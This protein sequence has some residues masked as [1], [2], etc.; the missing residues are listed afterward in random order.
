MIRRIR[1]CVLFLVATGVLISQN[2][3]PAGQAKPP[4]APAPAPAPPPQPPPATVA[5]QPT[6]PG[7]LNL[8]NA[9]LIQVIDILARDLKINYILDPRVK[10]SVTI[11]TYGEIRAVDLR[12]LLET[13]L[14]ING[15]AMVQVGNIYRIVPL[16]DV[17]RLP[18]P[19]Q[20][21]ARELPE[22]ERMILNMVFLKYVAVA[23]IAKLLQPF[24]GESASMTEYDPANLLLILDN[25]RN[26]KRT[27]DLIA[28]FDSDALATQRVKLF[29]VTHGRP[30]DL[31]QELDSIFKA[32]AMSDKNSPIRFMA[33]DRISTIL[34]VA[35]NAGIFTEVENW[36][37]KL[38][39]PVKLTAG[40]AENH[41]YRLKYGRAEII[42]SVIMRLYGGSGGYG[43]GGGYGG[44]GGFGGLGGGG[45]QP[46]G[47]GGLGL[48]GPMGSPYGDAMSGYGG[49]GMGPAGL[50]GGAS[51]GG[52]QGAALA[53]QQTP[54]QTGAGAPS[55]VTP[56]ATPV[57]GSVGP[58]ASDLTG[59]Y[60]GTPGAGRIPSLPRVIP[61]PF[62][63]TILVQATPQ[64]WEQISRL[65]AEIDVAPRQ[66]LIQ[67]KVYEVDL[68]GAWSA[69]VEAVMAARGPASERL[70]N[71]AS[72]GTLTLSAG[73]LV[74]HARELLATLAS[75]EAVT[76][77]KVISAPSLIATDSIPASINVG[78]E[79][80][81]V[82]ATAASGV[83]TGGNTVFAQSVVGRNT[84]VTLNILARVNSSGIV[85]MVINQEVSAPQPAPAG[86][87]VP[88][89]PTFSKRNVQTQVTVQDGDTIS[90]GG[91]IQEAVTDSSGGIPVLHRIPYLGAA[92]GSKNHSK[93][94]TELVVFLTP[95]VIYDTNQI[96]DATDELKSSLKKLQKIIKE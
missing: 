69:G 16:G 13:I 18:V 55:T 88:N 84:G 63:N 85:T 37:K 23:D 70:W 87:N 45:Y 36:L 95:R 91:I 4:A 41:V 15:A 7:G 20:V 52:A 9:S 22:D 89:S 64:Q 56:G 73:L 53:A 43:Y 78:Q 83:Q 33:I 67:A 62:D 96:T 59:M 44:Y 25:S 71:G 48:G 17:S 10:G 50:F 47:T 24:L 6:P 34:A 90:I 51:A 11:N 27:M 21:S 58:G 28:M 82:T 65:I 49:A 29:E 35:P 80:P 3:P 68:T 46:Y 5:A 94:R 92:F 79:V 31:V 86:V 57:P 60:L 39:V 12:P 26:M 1:A 81:T 14:R 54:T 42:G 75:R 72:N 32:Y 8:Q 30:S 2:P 38:D 40:A 93:T 76:H 74:G 77:A 61:N 19:P 66:V